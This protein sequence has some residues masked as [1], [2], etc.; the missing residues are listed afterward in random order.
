MASS[1][2]KLDCDRHGVPQYA[3]ETELF[4]EYVERAWDL[5][6]GREGQESLQVSTPLHL[7]AQLSS[8]AYESV[9]KL[10]HSK[11]RTTTSE[12]R[13]TLDGMKLL[14]KT[15][16]EAVAQEAPVRVN[17]LFLQYF[18]SPSVWRKAQESM[19]QYIIRR[20]ADFTRLKEASSETELSDNLKCML[21]LIFS[22]ID[23]KEQQNIL[24]SVNNEYNY[25]KVSHA[26]RI[27]FPTAMNRPVMRKDY[28]GA[29]RSSMASTGRH[30]RWKGSS[31]GRQVFAATDEIEETYDPDDEDQ[32]YYEDEEP[33]DYEALA[34]DEDGSEDET[35]DALINEMP[36][37]L[38][39]ADVAEAFATIAQHRF[40]GKGKGKKGFGRG[41]SSTGGTTSFPFRATGDLSFDQK[42]RENR[43]AATAFLKSVTVCTACNQK[44]HWVGD[45]ECP[46]SSRKGKGKSPGNNSN[47]AK[48]K[49]TS[50]KK[51]TSTTYFVL[52]D[53]DGGQD[54]NSV[55][56][57]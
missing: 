12:G 41:T 44:G 35:L 10:D 13:P 17:E 53:R 36:E 43:K 23:N 20:E 8:T 52:H 27:Q 50:P 30:A 6:Y 31:K 55:N 47:V 4:E 40:K 1:G 54:G 18:Y 45:A 21:L 34:A 33:G 5:Y 15:L 29:G 26:L 46:R 49:S 56:Y 3:G 25:R 22:G 42:A 32:A 57:M 16:K 9:R 38:E 39:D 48:K 37:S 51:K 28:L 14:L 19:G 24:A 11:L 7:R 2:S